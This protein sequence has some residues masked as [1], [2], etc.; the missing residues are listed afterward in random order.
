MKLRSDISYIKQLTI[1]K[2]L[3]R[4]GKYRS[5]YDLEILFVYFFDMVR[6]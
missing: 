3:A 1:K 5:H 2:K 4:Y 6:I